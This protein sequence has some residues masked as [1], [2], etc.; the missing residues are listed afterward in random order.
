MINGVCLLFKRKEP[1]KKAFEALYTVRLFRDRVK[2]LYSRL[3][4]R[5]NELKNRMAVLELRGE[6]YLAKRYAEEIVKLDG[7]LKSLSSLQ[8]VLEK[9]DTALQHAIIVREFSALVEDLRPILQDLSQ[10]SIIKS[11][12]EMGLLLADLEES[13]RELADLQ[14][15]PPSFEVAVQ[16]NSEIKAVLEEAKNILRKKLEP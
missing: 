2:R 8:L 1:L 14:V 3:D 9:I 6:A 16:S 5:K 12:P 7:L 11:I 15:A 10:Q 4:E 13:V